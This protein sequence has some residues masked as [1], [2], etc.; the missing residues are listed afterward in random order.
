MK[1]F[2]GSRTKQ[3]ACPQTIALLLFGLVVAMTLRCQAAGLDE[4]VEPGAPERIATGFIFTEGP[5]WHP[6]GYLLFSDIPA[7][8]IYKWTPDGTVDVFRSPSG[9]ANGLVFDRQGRLIA[10]E[11]SNRRISRTNLDGTIVTLAHEYNGSRLNSP[12]DAAVKS[13]GSIYFTDPPYG[14]TARLGVPGTQEL[15][16]SGVYRLLPDGETLELVVSDIYRPNGL[17]FSPDEKILYVANCGGGPVYAFDVQADGLLVNRRVFTHLSGWPD[18]IKVDVRGN[19][20]VTNNTSAIRVYDRS[21]KH[22]GDIIMPESTENCVFGGV[23]SR[24]LFITSTTSVYQVKMKVRGVRPPSS[25]FNGDG[26]INCADICLM[27]DQWHTDNPRYDIA[28]PLLGDGIVDVQ[29]LIVLTDRFEIEDSRL[30]ARWGLDEQEWHIAY[31]SAGDNDAILNGDPMWQPT[32]GMINGALQ[33]GGI[34]DYMSAPF[35]LDPTAGPF[36]VFA[37]IKGSEA[38]RVIISQAGSLCDWLATD[39]TGKLQ[40]TLPHPSFPPLESDLVI[41]DDVWHHIGLV[42]DAAS[43]ILYVDGAEAA[44]NNVPPILPAQGGLYI[45]AGKN[46]E[47]GTHWSGLIDDI[48]IYNVALSPEE[49]EVLAR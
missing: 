18:G 14:L 31:D 44:G 26:E 33:F 39:P 35:I 37:W 21:G 49:I 11:H 9:H 24:T 29:D 34:D 45:G 47:P 40:T 28:P 15:P 38:G 8:T 16:F 13:D 23:D 27:V 30:V 43:T 46:L 48:R 22:L 3:A 36:S 6:D 19:V 32:L 2:H 17:A 41:T 42:C 1:W 20:Y 5:A 7:N 10:C 12:N 25:D 4:L